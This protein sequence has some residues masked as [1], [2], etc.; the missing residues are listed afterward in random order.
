M[1]NS[2]ATRNLAW[3]YA[4][5]VYVVICSPAQIVSFSWSVSQISHL[6]DEPEH[7]YSR[8]LLLFSMAP[9]SP[10]VEVPLPQVPPPDIDRKVRPAHANISKGGAFQTEG[11]ATIYVKNPASIQK[12]VR[13]VADIVGLSL[14]SLLFS[15]IL[16]SWEDITCKYVLPNRHRTSIS[17]YQKPSAWGMSTIHGMG[18]NSEERH[19]L[20]NAASEE[21]N[22]EMDPFLN[23][24]SYNE[25]MFIHRTITLPQWKRIPTS[26]MI[27]NAIHTV[28]ESLQQLDTLR[29]MA[30]DYQWENVRCHLNTEPISDLSA[31]SS[32][33]RQAS[34]EMNEVVGFDWGSCAWRHC[35]AISDI[36]EAIDEMDQLLGVLEPHEIMFCIDIVERSLRDILSVVPWQQY[37]SEKDITFYNNLPSYASAVSRIENDDDDAVLS[38][39]DSEYFKA[40]QELRID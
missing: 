40:L 4:V 23:A 16:I 17:L 26:P 37:A 28:I 20:I 13:S 39:I 15:I 10:E 27:S 22:F 7:A 3:R 12:Q 25:V 2:I 29:E 8:R 34:S 38:R 9:T 33:L 35:G 30:N 1:A 21:Q 36:Q 18:F 32:I 31:Q 24:P 19:I 5:L 14:L 11:A 6:H